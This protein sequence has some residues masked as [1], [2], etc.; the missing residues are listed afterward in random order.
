MLGLE[1]ASQGFALAPVDIGGRAGDAGQPFA[2]L[3]GGLLHTTAGG[4]GQT[5]LALGRPIAVAQLQQQL[6][7]AGGPQGLQILGVEGEFA[8]HGLAGLKADALEQRSGGQEHQAAALHH[9]GRLG[10][11]PGLAG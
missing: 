6:R 7:Q 4:Q 8:G 1:V 3:L 9:A 10:P 11:G 2:H 5:Q